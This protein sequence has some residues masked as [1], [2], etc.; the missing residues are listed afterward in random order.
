MALVGFDLSG[1]DPVLHTPCPEE[2][3]DLRHG[4]EEKWK[5][6]EK[7]HSENPGIYFRNNVWYWRPLWQYV[8]DV[9]G[10]ILT[11]DDLNHGSY[12]DGHFI[13]KAKSVR[14]ARRLNQL[15]DDGDVATH[16]EEY[17]KRRSEA[18]DDSPYDHFGSHYPFSEDNVKNFAI[19]AKESGGFYI[20]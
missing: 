13:S 11:D 9:C 10:D 18:K 6:E 14:I 19:F 8:T 4:T 17:E 12:N 15:I 20:C 2:L 5:L 1:K 3:K 16:E 7:W